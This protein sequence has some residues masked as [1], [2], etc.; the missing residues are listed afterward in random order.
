MSLTLSLLNLVSLQEASGKVGGLEEYGEEG[1]DGRGHRLTSPHLL[2]TQV[3]AAGGG[4]KRNRGEGEGVG[5]EE[6]A[7]IRRP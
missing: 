4:D 2:L 3:G 6:W 5:W 1:G 7:I